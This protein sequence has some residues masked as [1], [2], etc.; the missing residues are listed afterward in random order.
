MVSKRKKWYI[1]ERVYLINLAVR[2][3]ECLELAKE[4]NI[5]KTQASNILKRKAKIFG[6][7]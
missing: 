2:C 6:G 4:F 1:E 5:R 3:K 7:I